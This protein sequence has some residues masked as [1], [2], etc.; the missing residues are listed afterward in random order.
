[1]AEDVTTDVTTGPREAVTLVTDT[2]L[3]M[4]IATD[5]VRQQRRTNQAQVRHSALAA[6][7]DRGRR[8]RRFNSEV[9]GPEEAPRGLPVLVLIPTTVHLIT[10]VSLTRRIS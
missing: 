7:Y 4:D 6:D 5:S 3:T 9:S 2:S 1:M 8:T 10:G